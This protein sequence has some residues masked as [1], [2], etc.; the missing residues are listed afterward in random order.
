MLIDLL[1]GLTPEQK[2][3]LERLGISRSRRSDWLH[4]RRQPTLAQILVLC[5]VTQTDPKPLVEWLAEQEANPAQLDYFR[6]VKERGLGVLLTAVFAV[7][8]ATPDPVFA[9]CSSSQTQFDPLNSG[10]AHCRQF[11]RRWQALRAWLKDRTSGLF[12]DLAK[13]IQKPC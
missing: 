4:A 11:R 12:F 7:A 8:L 2:A 3:E 13:P 5:M 1:E 10:N 6:Q 9:Q